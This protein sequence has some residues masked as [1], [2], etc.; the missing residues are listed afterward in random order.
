MII[1]NPQ[2]RLSWV[3]SQQQQLEFRVTS[4]RNELAILCQAIAT[5]RILAG[6]SGKSR[7]GLVRQ[8]DVVLWG[9][10]PLFERQVTDEVLPVTLFIGLIGASCKE[11]PP[12]PKLCRRPQVG[13]SS[14]QRRLEVSGVSLETDSYRLFDLYVEA[15]AIESL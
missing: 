4:L 1:T 5:I 13:P 10:D 15:V 3:S 9:A 14:S 7:P 6:E 2:S 11:D 8:E 12:N